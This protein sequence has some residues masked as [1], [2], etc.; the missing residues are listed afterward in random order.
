MRIVDMFGLVFKTMFEKKSRVL[1]TISG[2]IIG[3]FT[4]VF[5]ILVM[6]GL[7]SAKLLDD[8]HVHRIALASGGGKSIYSASKLFC[9]G[10]QPYEIK[11][12]YLYWLTKT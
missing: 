12:F 7:T 2:I 9:R 11:F 5:F 1:L 10:M 4:F 3:I 8:L 6:N